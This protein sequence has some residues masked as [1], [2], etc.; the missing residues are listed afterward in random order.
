MWLLLHKTVDSG[1]A[2]RLSMDH[3]EAWL[4]ACRGSSSR[5][6]WHRWRLSSAHQMIVTDAAMHGINEL[7]CVPAGRRRLSRG[8]HDGRLPRS[9]IRAPSYES[10]Q[11]EGTSWAGTTPF[12][13]PRPGADMLLSCMWAVQLDDL[14]VK[15]GDAHT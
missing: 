7:A 12:H 15:L 5:R 10:C 14:A 2:L 11:E 1:H 4:L 9:A 6:R 13:L 8:W 3:A